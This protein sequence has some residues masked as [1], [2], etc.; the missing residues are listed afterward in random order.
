MDLRPRP[1]GRETGRIGTGCLMRPV[2][3]SSPPV[4]V[5][6]F[7][8]VELTGAEHEV[9]GPR[10][11][12]RAHARAGGSTGGRGGARRRPAAPGDD[13][14]QRPLVEEQGRHHAGPLP[15]RPEQRQP[16]GRRGRDRRRGRGRR[17]VRRRGPGGDRAGG[18]R[19]RA[20]RRPGRPRRL[21]PAGLQPQARARARGRGREEAGDPRPADR[22][23]P[24]HAPRPRLTPHPA[25]GSRA[26]GRNPPRCGGRGPRRG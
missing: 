3:R 23:G 8:A 4:A 7:L 17:R 13:H 12:S 20:G 5:T 6:G 18:L 2:S 25:A 19:P 14:G 1:L 26:A 16:A 21:R 10:G 24:G 9:S 15:A 11:T 22:E